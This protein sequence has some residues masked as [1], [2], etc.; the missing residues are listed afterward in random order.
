MISST[1]MMMMMIFFSFAI[2]LFYDVQM[3]KKKKKKLNHIQLT[4]IVIKNLII[5]YCPEQGY[6]I[7]KLKSY[8]NE[9]SFSWEY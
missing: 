1:M 5:F 3:E 6:Y 9:A 7:L 8:K 2:C 4:E